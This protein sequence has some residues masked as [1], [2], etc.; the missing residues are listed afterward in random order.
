MS[1]TTQNAIAALLSELDQ[2]IIGASIKTRA[3]IAAIKVR[4]QNQCIGT[5]LP[6]EHDLEVALS[7]YRAILAIHRTPRPIVSEE[8]G[9]V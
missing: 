3:S 4:K 6:L 9:A 5:L 8:S 2:H 1:I 7:L